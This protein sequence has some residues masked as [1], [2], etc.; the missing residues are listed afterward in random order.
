[1]LQLDSWRDG[2]AAAAV[3]PRYTVAH[4]LSIP[5]AA[6]LVIRDF[7]T[8]VV[9]AAW[10][11]N[12]P[13]LGVL[14]FALIGT[15][16]YFAV[17]DARDAVCVRPSSPEMFAGESSRSSLLHI[18][19]VQLQVEAPAL[20]EQ[21]RLGTPEKMLAEYERLIE[22][23]RNGACVYSRDASGYAM[24]SAIGS[25]MAA[26]FV[27]VMLLLLFTPALGWMVP[28]HNFWD[29]YVAATT[30][31]AT[32]LALVPLSQWYLNFGT[33]FAYPP[34]W[35]GIL[36]AFVGL[37]GWGF[38]WLRASGFVRV[39]QAIV[40]GIAGV[41]TWIASFKTE[42]VSQAAQMLFDQNAAFILATYVLL[43]V[44]MLLLALYSPGARAR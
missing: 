8:E 23:S 37:V 30:L 24:Y 38:I 22:E 42:W 36:T 35:A 20:A 7:P 32:W 16:E 1:M 2:L 26:F 27:A 29:T 9:R 15:A 5:L 40:V 11:R 43:G 25:L 39:L 3:D 31:L 19:K 13:V 14:A 4:V 18:R 34:L 21:T 12:A 41:V 10:S 17:Q 33:T 28:G 44:L 6:F